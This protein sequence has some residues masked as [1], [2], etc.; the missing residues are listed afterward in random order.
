[1]RGEGG[2]EG[3]GEGRNHDIIVSYNILFLC[4]MRKRQPFRMLPNVTIKIFSK[5]D[6]FCDVNMQ[7]F[8]ITASKKKIIHKKKLHGKYSI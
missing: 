5:M 4:H 1:M 6:I 3:G 8:S 7:I 2:W